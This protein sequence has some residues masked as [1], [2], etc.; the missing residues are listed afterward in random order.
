MSL[1]N[2][3]LTLSLSL[4]LALAP[5]LTLTLSPTLPFPL[6][7]TLTLTRL[8]SVAFACRLL[9]TAPPDAVAPR[10]YAEGGGSGAEIETEPTLLPVALDLL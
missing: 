8:C 2:L 5:A 4:V 3:T 6:T 9:R 10:F 7:L 1:V